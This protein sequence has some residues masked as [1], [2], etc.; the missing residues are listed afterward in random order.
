MSFKNIML[1]MLSV[2][3]VLNAAMSGPG[4]AGITKKSLAR[5]NSGGSVDIRVTY[6]NPLGSVADGEL[7]FEVRMNS[8]S[9]D[10]DVY[11]VEELAVLK[12]DRGNEFKPLGW[13]DPGG[14][15][16]HRFGILKFSDATKTGSLVKDAKGITLTI[17]GVS[18]V[19]K[20]VFK[21]ELPIK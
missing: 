18:D 10:L 7:A 15:G 13:F 8:H 17:S 1:T 4:W 6:L 3:I 12:D 21:W 5:T 2:A 16:H 14:G 9:V 19:D 11:K 20:R